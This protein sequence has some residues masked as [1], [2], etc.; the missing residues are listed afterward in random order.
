MRF[1]QLTFTFTFDPRLAGQPFGPGTCGTVTAGLQ[2]RR[3]PRL[4]R[5]T[6]LGREQPRHM[7][8]LNRFQALIAERLRVR[9]GQAER[10][11]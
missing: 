4:D 8:L 5:S 9:S 1:K 6:Q 11:H 2:R 3:R 7:A 10:G